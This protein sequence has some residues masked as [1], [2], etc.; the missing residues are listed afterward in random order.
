MENTPVGDPSPAARLP[1]EVVDAIV[2]YLIGDTAS[3]RTCSLI[4]HPWYTAAVPRLHR[5]LVIYIDRYKKK[6]DWLKLL[7]MGSKLGLLPFVTGLFIYGEHWGPYPSNLR[8]ASFTPQTTVAFSQL[9][10]VQ[11][12]TITGLD[13]ASFVPTIHLYFG[14]FS[15]TVRFLSLGRILGSDRQIAFF[16]GLFPHLENL[17]LYSGWYSPEKTE[18]DPKLVPLFVPPLRGEL[19]IDYTAAHSLATTIVD[20]FGGVR[21]H[22]MIFHH[23]GGTQPLLYGCADALVSLWLDVSAVCGENPSSKPT[24]ALANHVAGSHWD[25]DLS[26]NTSLLEL[27]IGAWSL[28]G[29][30][31]TRAPGTIPGAFRAVLSSVRSPTFSDVTVTYRS[32][33]FYHFAYSEA[34]DKRAELGDEDT[35]YQ[36]QF[37]VF[38]EMYKARDF[39]LVLWADAVGDTS[40]RELRR[41]VAAET[42]KGGLPPQVVI[43]S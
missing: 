39:R 16:I 28:I 34:G 13:I 35:W 18:D 21:F 7:K 32:A 4:S 37:D 5:T 2:T 40:M 30:L 20:L 26:R 12:L 41:A 17:Y 25:L 24:R 9:T 15:S 14:H 6:G 33:C 3:L 8:R 11:K 22:R 36:N 42:A 31:K 1:Q 19:T 23:V 27:E 29:A 43:I 10:N 38:R